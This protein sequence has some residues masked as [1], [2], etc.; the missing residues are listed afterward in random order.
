MINRIQQALHDRFEA[1]KS[2]L[3]PYP[4]FS[5]TV[6]VMAVLIGVA[7]GYVWGAVG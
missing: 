4:Y 2:A 3:K 1:F 6:I 7:I 5:A